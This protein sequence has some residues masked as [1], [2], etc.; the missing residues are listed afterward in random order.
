MNDQGRQRN[1][2]QFISNMTVH[3]NRSDSSRMKKDQQ[4]YKNRDIKD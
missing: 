3:L 4:R 2:G 1:K